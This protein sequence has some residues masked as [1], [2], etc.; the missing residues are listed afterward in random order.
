[1]EIYHFLS[2]TKPIILILL[3]LTTITCEIANLEIAGTQEVHL[4]EPSEDA[5]ASQSNSNS[6]YGRN[7]IM[8]VRSYRTDSESFNHRIYIMF[9]LTQLDQMSYVSSAELRLYKCIEGN[10]VG[11]RRIDV[12]RVLGQWHE[13]NITWENKPKSAE[14]L[15]SWADVDGTENWYKWDVTTD[16][17]SWIN[18]SAQNNG[19]C[20][21]DSE[22]NS[23][24]DYASVFYSR[25]A[26]EMHLYRPKLEVK[27]TVIGTQMDGVVISPFLFPAA[28]ILGLLLLVILVK[29]KR[30]EGN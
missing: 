4:F 25:E 21:V 11:V 9:N 17:R 20:L 8:S 13:T 16:V 30:R 23:S 18:G 26:Y 10:K 22:E 7:E 24:V 14:R 27:T 6:N 28:L 3:A 19:F 15:S 5:Y 12:K 1:M 2:S 29:F